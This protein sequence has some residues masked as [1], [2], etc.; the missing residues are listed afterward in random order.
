MRIL[1]FKLPEQANQMAKFFSIFYAA[2]NAAALISMA[3]TPMLR[4]NV[5]CF[6]DD[7]CYSLAFGGPIL[8]MVAAIGK[9][10]R[11]LVFKQY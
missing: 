11:N 3:V 7:D 2:I 10:Y 4:A 1:Q 5:Q 9:L 8:F 6:G